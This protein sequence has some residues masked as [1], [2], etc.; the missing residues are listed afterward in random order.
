MRGHHE[1]AYHLLAAALHAAEITGD[2]SRIEAIVHLAVEQ[3]AAV[4]D[5]IDHPLA[6]GNARKRGNTPLYESLAG[7]A[8]KA[9]P[10]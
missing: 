10:D 9:R 7:T 3:G 1:V 2:T 6:T 5:Q 8:R 4:D